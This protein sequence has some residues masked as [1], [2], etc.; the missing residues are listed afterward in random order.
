M[1]DTAQATAEAGEGQ[2]DTAE[3]ENKTEVQSAEFSEA[4]GTADAGAGGSIDILL[5]MNIPVTVTIGKTQMPIRSLLRLGPG[6]V[7]RLDKPIDEPAELY[8]KDS[9]FATGAIVVLDGQFAVRIEQILS[10]AVR[11]D[12]QGEPKAE[13][14]QN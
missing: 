5:D 12:S 3:A 2:N 8:L 9:K 4:A 6:S 10:S 14:K 11:K 1:A 7:V 13:Q